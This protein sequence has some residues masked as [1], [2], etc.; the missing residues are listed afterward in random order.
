M[1][2]ALP[3]AFR[4]TDVSFE[5]DTGPGIAND[6]NLAVIAALTVIGLALT[7]GFAVLFPHTAN[8]EALAFIS[9]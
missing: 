8:V 3:L 4:E 1:P 2:A 6:R 7:I 9:T 5:R